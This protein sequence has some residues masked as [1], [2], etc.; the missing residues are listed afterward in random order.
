MNSQEI[1]SLQK[2]IKEAEKG[3]SFEHVLVFSPL[4]SSGEELDGCVHY[5]DLNR[6]K[7]GRKEY[8]QARDEIKELKGTALILS[9]R[10]HI[11]LTN[12]LLW[13]CSNVVASICI[14]SEDPYPIEVGVSKVDYM[15][16][17][18]Q[19]DK[20]QTDD[21]AFMSGW[22]NSYNRKNFLPEEIKEYVEDAYLKITPYINDQS[23]LLEVG[24]GSG[25]IAFP[26]IPLC[27]QYDGCDFSN[28]VLAVLQKRIDAAGFN[29]TK[30]Y[31]LSADEIDALTDS[32]NIILMSSVT[33]YFSGYNYMREVVK[34]CIDRIDGEGE[35][36][37]LDIFDLDR[38]QDYKESVA[39]YAAEHPS[40]KYKRDFSHELYFPR[41]YWNSLLASLNGIKNIEVTDKIGKI[42]NEIN[43][44]RYD[45]RIEVDKSYKIQK[46]MNYK[47]QYGM[48]RTGSAI[49]DE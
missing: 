45:V 23:R 48:S 47:P 19:T 8:I 44:Y 16:W 26:L 12:R 25:L 31:K 46:D 49:L 32:Y 18:L 14:D 24:I 27:K 39:A 10:G 34:K 35:L 33:E 28:Q 41:N 15:V 38:L 40:D 13:E 4:V 42:D 6:V 2:I 20:A 21:F 43:R 11:Y 37:L 3:I 30:L 9:D 29:N 17:D 5:Y 7:Y 22:C 1:P 36:F